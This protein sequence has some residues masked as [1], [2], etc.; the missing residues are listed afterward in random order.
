MSG[1]RDLFQAAMRRWW[2]TTFVIATLW[3]WQRYAVVS[4]GHRIAEHRATL[5]NLIETRDALLAENTTLSSRVRIESI[6]S[7]RLGLKPTRDSQVIRL[8]KYGTDAVPPAGPNRPVNGSNSKSVSTPEP[9]VKA[10]SETAS[11]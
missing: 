7:A 11:P 1:V 8:Q 6:T 4:A 3:V 5:A 2:I 10:G 9:S